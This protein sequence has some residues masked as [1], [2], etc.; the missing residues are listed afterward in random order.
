[1]AFM[2]QGLGLMGP[3]DPGPRVKNSHTDI[4]TVDDCVIF[5]DTHLLQH[6]CILF[7]YIYM[8]MYIYIT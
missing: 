8:C 6:T 3:Y 1:M 7:S 5:L 2:A 4:G